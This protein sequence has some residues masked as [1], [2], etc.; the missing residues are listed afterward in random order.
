M[1]RPFT[2]LKTVFRLLI[3]VLLLG[4]VAGGG[5]LWVKYRPAHATESAVSNPMLPRIDWDV[6][7]PDVLRL[8]SDYTT[9]LR[10]KTSVVRPAP[11]PGR[12]T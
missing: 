9:A 4:G 6:H 3:A 11:S 12:A 10:V 5:I 7:H 8:P 1:M 2:I